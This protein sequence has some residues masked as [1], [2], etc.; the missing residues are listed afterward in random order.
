MPAMKRKS[1]CGFGYNDSIETVTVN[2]RI[3][4]KSVRVSECFIY[5]KW[6]NMIKRCYDKKTQ[7][8][9]PSYIGCEVSKKWSRFSAFKRWFLWYVEHYSLDKSKQKDLCLDKDIINKGNKTY[10]PESCALVDHVTNNFSLSGGSK[11]ASSDMRVS[12]R[13]DTLKYSVSIKSP[14]TGRHQSLGCY[15]TKSEALRVSRIKKFEFGVICARNQK[16]KRVSSGILRFSKSLLA[17][18]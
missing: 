2:K 9:F 6:R 12:F 14:I 3:N 5:S 4:G 7:D 17:G 8:R 11:R 13:K 15:K 16:D 18:V 10:S 1:I